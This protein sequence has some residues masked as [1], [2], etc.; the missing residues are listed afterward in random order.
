MMKQVLFCLSLVLTMTISS[1]AQFSAGVMTGVGHLSQK[2]SSSTFIGIDPAQPLLMAGVYGQFNQKGIRGFIG[3]VQLRYQSQRQAFRYSAMNPNDP[4]A[5]TQP[6]YNRYSYL[7][8]TPYVGIRPFGQLE[9]AAGPEVSLLIQSRFT[10]LPT[11][12]GALLFGYNVKATY[13]LGRFGLEGGYSRQN[14]AYDRAGSS[15]F[16]NRYVYGVVK[17]SLVR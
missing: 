10:S 2:A 7:V 5:L 1:Y 8:A 9:I 16:Y 4:L 15:E 13:W 17:Y 6:Y 11:D 14:T 3:G 12:P